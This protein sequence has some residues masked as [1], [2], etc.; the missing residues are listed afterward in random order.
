MRLPFVPEAL[1]E[2][3]AAATNYEREHPV[4]GSLFVD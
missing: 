2:L 3:E 4:Y 1:D